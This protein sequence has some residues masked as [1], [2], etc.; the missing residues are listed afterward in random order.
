MGDTQIVQFTEEDVAQ[1][2]RGSHT[3]FTKLFKQLFHHIRFFCE[4]IVKDEFEAEDIA[5]MSFTKYLERAQ[6]FDSL[7]EIKA[8]LYVTAR[9]F[10]FDYLE[11]QRAK[12]N[13]SQQMAY[14]TSEGINHEAT[15][16]EYEAIMFE[17]LFADVVKEVEN[18]PE[19]CRKVFKMVV[20]EK[21][22]AD[23]V[24]RQLGISPGTVRTHCSNAMKKLKAI[25]SEKGLVLIIFI[26][27][28]YSNN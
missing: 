18:L 11:K 9:N 15:R 7:G 5:V 24:A 2:K 19:Q 3:A 26:L 27:S 17:Q 28:G 6:N 10:C 13:Y 8:F 20:F 16:F 4:R 22:P 14:L 12:Q 23:V 21:V 1:L 25:F